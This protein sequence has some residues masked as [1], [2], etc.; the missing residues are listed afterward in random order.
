MDVGRC[1]RVLSGAVGAIACAILLV[2]CEAESAPDEAAGTEAPATSAPTDGTTRPTCELGGEPLPRTGPSAE[3][4]VLLSGDDGP[5]VEAIVYP[6]PDYEGNPWSQWGQ[7]LV[8]PDGRFLSAIGDHLGVDGNSYLYEYLPETGSL[9]QLTDVLSL[10]DH[11]PGAWGY[12][13]I[14]AQMVPGPCGE[15]Y[16]ATYWGTNEGLTF[17]A[18][19]QGD[20]LFRIDP[21]SDTIA[22]L[23]TP[24]PEHGLPSLAGWADGGLVYGEA[25]DPLNDELWQGPFFVYD[26][27]R[28]ET[29]FQDDDAAHVG[30]RNIAV[31]ADGRAYFSAWDG[32]LRMYDPRAGETMDVPG[33]L[34]GAW[35]RASTRPASDGTVYGVTT[36]PDVFFAIE[37]SGEIRTIGPARGY[38][39]SIALDP[40]GTHILYVPGGHGD[41]WEQGTPLISVDP[42]TGQ[43]EV[44]VELAPAAEAALGLRL[45]GTYDLAVDPSRRIAYI[46][47][48]AGTN[49]SFGE[50]VL[51]IVHLP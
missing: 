19:Y 31:D 29:V 41:S 5:R 51:V 9:T 3:P 33:R 20:R 37:P 34:P 30:F 6:R 27:A 28:R 45:G 32:A 24:V 11:R 22:D 43:E 2:S 18:S 23:G 4:T 38:T 17:S 13:K 39:P 44:L 36:D 1:R 8:L 46:G 7:G 48:N 49:D 12:G 42:E 40:D 26:V 21:A 10:T 50:V 16:V 35:M 47:M 15:V 25:P 14:H